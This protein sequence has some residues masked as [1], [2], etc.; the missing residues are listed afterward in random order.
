MSNLLLDDD[1]FD[2]KINFPQLTA[3]D[4][5]STLAI[6]ME[7]AKQEVNMQ[8]KILNPTFKDLIHFPH[9]HK[10]FHIFS[11]LGTLC[12]LS[13]DEELR[14]VSDH[15]DDV[16][17]ELVM[18]WHFDKESFEQLNQFVNS[19]A[20]YE[21][22]VIRQRILNKNLTDWKK[23]GINLPLSQQKAFIKNTAKINQL[24]T[25]FNNNITD[26]TESMFLIVDE[27]LLKGLSDRS[28]E[29][30]KALSQEKNVPPG[31][32]YID[33]NSGLFSDVMS[34]VKNQH[35]RKKIYKLRKNQCL[36]GEFNN[37]KIIDKI[38]KYCQKNSH[39]LGYQNVATEV[40]SENMA[41]T[42]E[43]V[44]KF[45]QEI[46]DIVAPLARKESLE[47]YEKGAVL[48]NRP[49]HIWDTSFLIN[50]FEKEFANIDY[51]ELRK[52]FPLEH[53]LKGL[54]QFCKEKFNIEFK[55]SARLVWHEDVKYYDV[56]ENN[57]HIGGLFMDLY[58]RNGKRSGAWLSPLVTAC[59]NDIQKNKAYALLVCNIT[60]NHG[61]STVSF[62]DVQAIFHEM[63][64]GIHHLLSKVQE[65]YYSGFNNV[66]FDCIEF[67]SQLLE[68]FIYNYDVLKLISK[69]I[70]TG[71]PLD[72][73][74][75]KRL[76][77]YK[78]FMGATGII[79][80][81]IF[82]DIDQKLYNQNELHPYVIEEQVKRHWNIN[83][84]ADYDFYHTKTFQHIFGGYKA[85]YYAYQWAEV[86][87]SDAYTYL[88]EE[89][90]SSDETQKRFDSY[91]E[92]ILYTG[93]EHTMSA[94]YE[95]FTGRQPLIQG[96]L[97]QYI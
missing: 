20:F 55:E 81:I 52:Y 23:S 5:D 4:F 66:A 1:I 91:K 62:D 63:G 33:E 7:Q 59:D 18:Q 64:H 16:L 80:G 10:L 93:G 53:V 72:D 68:S 83:A 48:L 65:S 96:F 90:I 94:N 29:N 32:I 77:D 34:N 43:N 76:K 58:K 50:H 54:F 14:K 30:A 37:T 67:P 6:V 13:G 47:L 12:S 88:T 39:L 17:N 41:K 57:I 92:H 95:N 87:S 11:I 60:K 2:L 31:K 27:K 8:K 28:L 78:K 38:Y 74:I 71:L 15:Y 82:S 61:I 69:H 86:M 26:S 56:Y 36:K 22:S 73:D 9:V 3:A 49:V 19:P 84:N 21:Q 89:N 46:G 42:P 51:E 79:R 97:N 70:D 35:V 85:S 44:E 75:I 40:I 45:I 24:S 25:Q